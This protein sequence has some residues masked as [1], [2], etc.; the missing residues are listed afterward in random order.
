[1]KN[2]LFIITAPSSG[3]AETYLLR[4]LNSTKIK[5][6]CVLC[7]NSTSGE[8]SESYRKVT[9]FAYVGKLGYLN[10]IPYIKLI[11]FLKENNFDT[12][13]DFTGN[14]SAFTLM[15][16]KIV[17]I[18]KRIAFFRE[19][20]NQFEPTLFK[21]MYARM[22]TKLTNIYSTRILSNS[23]EALNHF[24]PNWERINSR[25]GV[26]YNGLDMDQLSAISKEE[27]RK[28]LHINNES[29]VIC[30]SGRY[31]PAKNHSMIIKCAEVLCKAHGDIIFVLIGRGIKEAIGDEIKKNRLENNILI[32]GY[33]D[34]VL[35]VIKCADL[36]YFPS[37]NEGQPNALIEAMASDLPFVASDIPS[38]KETVP[39]DKINS[40][41][42]PYR[43]KDNIEVLESFY[44]NRD[45]LKDA[46]CS[47]WAKENFNSKKLFNQFLN[48]LL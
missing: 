24:Y 42:D 36:F 11:K 9:K 21:K 46:S 4:F 32:L 30:H 25:Y 44:Y 5:K 7:K 34:D 35:D 19:S 22:V 48:E 20:R 23:Y 28:K 38:I 17:N 10:P 2:I 18:S 40:L 41:V 45:K 26:I 29:F 47:D 8:L 14:F 13:C 12:I 43:L 39:G 16:G 15:C 3:G 27:M 37:L 31:S 1:M 33:R 6:T